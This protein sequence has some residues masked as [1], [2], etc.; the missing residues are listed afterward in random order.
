MPPLP[1]ENAGGGRC[2][3]LGRIE[4]AET[5]P[6][7]LLG[8]DGARTTSRHGPSPVVVVAA[9]AVTDIESMLA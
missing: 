2:Q 1:A 9:V 8:G 4:A 7:R 6:R 5:R 3:F